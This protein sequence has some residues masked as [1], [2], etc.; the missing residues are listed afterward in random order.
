[1]ALGAGLVAPS[2]ADAAEK[3]VYMGLPRASQQ[4]FQATGSDANAF[5][6]RVATIH[7]GDTVKF[8]ARGFHTVD[9]PGRRTRPLPLITPNGQPV[10]G[11]VD[12]AGAPFW[13]NGQ[14]GLGF[15]PA[16][17]DLQFGKRLSYSGSKAVL[18]GL[19]ITNNP[20]ALRVRFTRAGSFRYFCDIHPGMTGR[21]RVVGQGSSV[22]SASADKRSVRRQLSAALRVARSITS[23]RTTPANTVDVGIE[24][25]GGVHFFGFVPDKLTV[26]RGSTVLFRMPARSTE[27]HTATTGPGNPENEPDSYLGKL[28]AS[29]QSPQF[30]PAALYPSDPPPG[31]VGLTPTSHGNGFWNTGA[32]DG[33][34]RSP[35]PP[36]GAVRFDGAGTY[37]IYCIIHPF[38]HGTITVT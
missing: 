25:K 22:P 19:P 31:I 18:S 26:A 38:L 2:A 9:L 3:T 20:K 37:E 30:D 34:A 36:R 29:L 27:V 17:L 12:A 6:P 16:L 23:G 24:G 28:A 14:S 8:A 10:A 32:L 5:F 15:N 21:V 1:L 4:A 33:D 35:T 7:V 11:A 13:F